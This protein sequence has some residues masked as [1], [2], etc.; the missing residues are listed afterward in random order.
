MTDVQVSCINKQPR[1]NA[2]EGITHL[3]GQGGNGWRWTRQQVAE[4]PATLRRFASGYRLPRSSTGYSRLLR[5]SHRA[6]LL[7]MYARTSVSD[8]SLRMM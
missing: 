5:S 4:V 8:R 1:Q 2:Y 7:S 3:G 6:A